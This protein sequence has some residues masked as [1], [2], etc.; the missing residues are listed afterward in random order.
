MVQAVIFM[1]QRGA[2]RVQTG[3]FVVLRGTGTKADSKGIGF[4]RPE[5]GFWV[6]GFGGGVAGGHV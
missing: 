6:L 1:V 3:S 2:A 4:E 5:M